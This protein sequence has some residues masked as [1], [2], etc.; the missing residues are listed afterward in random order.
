MAI[1]KIKLQKTVIS[2]LKWDYLCTSL[3][4]TTN[5]VRKYFREVRVLKLDFPVKKPSEEI[6]KQ[7]Y[8]LKQRY[9]R[10]HNPVTV[11]VNTKYL[12]SF[13]A[14]GF[15]MWSPKRRVTTLYFSLIITGIIS[16]KIPIGFWDILRPILM[17]CSITMCTGWLNVIVMK[18]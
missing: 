15:F 7:P 9:I 6:K 3:C 11:P 13:E 17:C 2:M 4:K 12:V 16:W 18:G 8:I 5:S 10:S 14:N 1:T